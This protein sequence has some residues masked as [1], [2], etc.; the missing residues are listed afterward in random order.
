MTYVFDRYR[1][2]EGS[3]YRIGLTKQYE[4]VQPYLL[5][6]LVSACGAESFVDVGANVGQYAVHFAASNPGMRVV[7]FEPDST[8]YLH[9]VTNMFLNDV[10]VEVQAVAASDAE[11]P[12]PFG[13]VGPMSGKNA[14]LDTTIHPLTDYE[15]G[16][17]KYARRIDS[18]ELSGPVAFKVDVE[19]HELAV[20]RGAEGVLASGDCVLQVEEYAISGVA[21]YLAQF[22]Y[23]PVTRAGHDH[24]YAPKAMRVDVKKLWEVAVEMM[25]EDR[26][27]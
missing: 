8:A 24:Y 6:L 27:G 9:L 16:V 14:L 15:H 25:I 3:A 11:G 12:M 20:L 7:A 17:E 23:V 10:V 21:D 5:Q 19:G 4:P 2:T 26:V 18:Y 1:W 22:G 13:V